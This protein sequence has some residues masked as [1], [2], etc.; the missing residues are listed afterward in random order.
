MFS[1]LSKLA[2]PVKFGYQRLSRMVSTA[3]VRG[4][5]AATRVEGGGDGK[6]WRQVGEGKE[7]EGRKEGRTG[8]WE[9]GK[10]G[11]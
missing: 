11:G 10:M 8:V 5:D 4:G 2:A 6:G 3:C 7:W 1:S 9:D